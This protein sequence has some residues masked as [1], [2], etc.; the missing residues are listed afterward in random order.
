MRRQLVARLDD[1]NELAASLQ[2]HRAERIQACVASAVVRIRL[3]GEG[4]ESRRV[5][6]VV[7]R[8]QQDCQIDERL[9]AQRAAL[10]LM[11]GETRAP[12]CVRGEPGRV[13]GAL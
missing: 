3:P 4:F 2:G 12:G 5:R 9:P 13:G 7:E 8:A 1:R 11:D 6:G 10:R